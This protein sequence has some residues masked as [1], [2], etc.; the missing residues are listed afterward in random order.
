MAESQLAICELAN[1]TTTTTNERKLFIARRWG[2]CWRFVASIQLLRLPTIYRLLNH[3]FYIY[4]LLLLFYFHDGWLLLLCSE[5][6][7][8]LNTCWW[9][10]MAEIVVFNL[11]YNFN[12]IPVYIYISI[13]LLPLLAS[14]NIENGHAVSVA[15]RT[16]IT[17]KQY[18]LIIQHC[19]SRIISVCIKICRRCASTC[20]SS[21]VCVCEWLS[22]SSRE[23]ERIT[24]RHLAVFLSSQNLYAAKRNRHWRKACA[25]TIEA[26]IY[27]YIYNTAVG[28]NRRKRRRGT[29]AKQWKNWNQMYQTREHLNPWECNKI[30]HLRNF[31]FILFII[32]QEMQ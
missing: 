16:I 22:A 12:F 2:A 32:I 19:R 26:H 13:Y 14:V 10:E 15:T 24:I 31:N 21:C 29:R 30:W 25:R 7:A 1:A 9:P 17:T 23:E 20:A 3:M 6:K 4:F 11:K 28:T 5:L 27:I 18:Q 8:A